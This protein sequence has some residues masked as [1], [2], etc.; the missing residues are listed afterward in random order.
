[1]RET[2]QAASISAITA[3]C[4]CFYFDFSGSILIIKTANFPFVKNQ[5]SPAH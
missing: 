2:L 5:P 3:A 4:I 1:M